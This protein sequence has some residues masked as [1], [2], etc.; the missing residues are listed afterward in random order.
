MHFTAI[1]Y[2]LLFIP[3][4]AYVV[5]YILKGRNLAPS[6]KVSSTSPFKTGIKS[7]KNYLIHLPFALRVITLSMLILVL[8]RPVTSNI[9][10]P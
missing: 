6:M 9:W 1:S 7:Y 3:L 10:V 2:S 8:M 4:I 5:W